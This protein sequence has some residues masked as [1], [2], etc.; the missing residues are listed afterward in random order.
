MKNLLFIFSVFLLI[1]GAAGAAHAVSYTDVYD[2][3]HVYMRG[4]LFGSDQSVSWTFD[5]TDNG[6][7]PTQQD[8]TAASISLNLT[9]DCGWDL[10]EFAEL[11]IGVNEFFW[12]VNSGDVSFEIA[13]LMTLSES[14]TVDAVLTATFGDF[15]FNYATLTAEAT[16]VTSQEGAAPV[17]EPA[18]ILLLG[19]GLIGLSGFMRKS[20]NWLGTK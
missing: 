18:N 13:S 8:V 2:A 6:F 20:K 19:A 17:P 14:G 15:Y 10:W 5:I 1:C 16:D 7:D 3:G 9:D 4:S 12:E 11:N